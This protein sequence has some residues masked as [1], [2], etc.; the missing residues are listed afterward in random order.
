LRLDDLHVG[1]ARLDE[2]RTA[3]RQIQS[4]GKPVVVYFS[5]SPS[6]GEY[7]LACAADWLVCPPVSTVNLDGLRAEATFYTDLMDK[8]GIEFEYERVGEYKSAV[9]T[10]SRT[11]L[12][13]PAREAREALLDDIFMELVTTVAADRDLSPDRVRELIDGGPLVSVD[14]ERAGLVDQIAYE[15]EL[16]QIIE[17]KI[18]R[19]AARV[20]FAALADRSYHRTAWGPIPKVAVIVA[21]GTMLP[22]TDRD[23]LLAGEVL[24]AQTMV[25]ALR[26]ARNDRD[27]KAIVLR[28]NSPG[29][30][31]I[32][33][34]LIKRELELARDKKP[35]VVSMADVAASGGYYIGC[36]ADS[37]FA[38]PAT[39]TGSIGVYY[40]KINLAGLYEK[41]GIDKE[42][43]TRG[44]HADMYSMSRP[45]S[46]QEREILRQQVHL[47][48]DNFIEVVAK[49]RRLE[50]EE[51]EHA[52]QGR[53]WT[54]K[55]AK[56]LGL[57]DE[58][59][60]LQRAIASAAQLA[61]IDRN[62][63]EVRLLPRAPWFAAPP[64]RLPGW[65]FGYRADDVAAEISAL[66]D[67]RIWYVLPWRLEIE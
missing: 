47:L 13:E 43:S 9:E 52:A 27:V 61:G 42:T 58:Y 17:D 60:G 38:S 56:D 26:E 20:D 8:L 24:G 46:E 67:E 64:I 11:S 6:D 19:G 31:G 59:G 48:Y 3:I 28:I 2:L 62:N 65:L 51:T 21:E 4:Q 25:A 32:S 44:A 53:V 12:S 45:F 30:S 5:S 7:Y 16:G 22:G 23:D 37:V 55:A 33:A 50:H 18:S 34:D 54:G 15:D 49:G 41:I 1:W 39:I 66:N 14:A 40:G 10:Y 63:Y 36:A 29:G 35:L 57:I